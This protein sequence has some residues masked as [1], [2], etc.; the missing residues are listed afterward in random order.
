MNM[1][2]TFLRRFTSMITACFLALTSF[3]AAQV[4]AEEGVIEEDNGSDNLETK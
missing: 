1:K 2:L 3:S 4:F